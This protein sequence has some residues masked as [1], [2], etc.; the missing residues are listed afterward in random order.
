MVSSLWFTNVYKSKAS[1]M[2]RPLCQRGSIPRWSL[3]PLFSPLGQM[4]GR[5]ETLPRSTLWLSRMLST[6]G[7]KFS[8]RLIPPPTQTP[9]SPALCLWSCASPEQWLI[10]WI[11]DCFCFLSAF[12]FLIEKHRSIVILQCLLFVSPQD[13]FSGLLVLEL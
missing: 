8:K 13:R 9:A 1:E 4:L 6:A 11:I 12:F 2:F 3:A 5:V 7:L 10:Q